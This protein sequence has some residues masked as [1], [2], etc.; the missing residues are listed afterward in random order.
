MKYR[1]SDIRNV[2]E[3]SSARETAARVAAGT[4]AR[5]LLDELGIK[6]VGHVLQI[7]NLQARTEDFDPVQTEGMLKRSS[8]L[9]ADPQIE[10][11]M[12]NLIEQARENGD[13]LGGIFE[14]RAFGVPAGL[15]SYVHWDRRLDG[16]LAAAL[17]SIQA[18]KGVEIGQGFLNAARFGSQVQDEIFYEKNRGF[19]RKTNHAGGIE[20]GVTNGETLVVRA[21]MKPIPTLNRP[22]LSVDITSKEPAR[23]AVERSDICAVPAACVTGEAVVAWELA[24]VCMEK[25]GGD[26]MDELKNNWECYKSYLCKV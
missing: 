9:C 2:L 11:L 19:Y 16:R 15:G 21:A 6:I 18:V 4:L 12:I 5:R 25:F 20:G 22:L 1:H 23:A 10:P 8:L 17:M 24:R 3:R 7:G 13:T 26:S 14:I